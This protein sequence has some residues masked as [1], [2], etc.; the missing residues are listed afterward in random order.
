MATVTRIEPGWECGE[1]ISFSEVGDYYV[2]VMLKTELKRSLH[3]SGYE[4]KAYIGKIFF[5]A[6][7]IGRAYYRVLSLKNTKL[8]YIP[9]G[10][11]IKAPD[12]VLRAIDAT[13]IKEWFNFFRRLGNTSYDQ[14]LKEAMLPMAYDDL[15]IETIPI[16]FIDWQTG[17]IVGNRFSNTSWE[18]KFKKRKQDENGNVVVWRRI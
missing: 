2:T 15:Q 6:T 13:W 14:Y 1:R 12:H 10:P 7:H 5:I 17:M 11:N 8:S 4:A 16:K 3:F 9:Y 18:W